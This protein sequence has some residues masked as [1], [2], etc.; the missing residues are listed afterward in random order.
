MGAT[1]PHRE[2]C[3]RQNRNQEGR[4]HRSLDPGDKTLGQEQGSAAALGRRKVAGAR[5]PVRAEQ[6]LQRPH[7]PELSAWAQ[8]SPAS[9]P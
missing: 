3:G 6:E 4:G 8:R 7:L 5:W 2:R 1:K 9:L